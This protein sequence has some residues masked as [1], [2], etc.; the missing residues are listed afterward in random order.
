ML[1]NHLRYAWRT[2]TRHRTT[3]LI[4]ILG[5]SLGLCACIAI[6]TITHY[7]FSFDDFHPDK[8]RIYR[9]G[10]R[11]LEN[12]NSNQFAGVFYTEDIPPPA[13]D[14]IRADI[15]GIE[16]VAPY[17]LFDNATIIAT[18]DYFH[19]FR[20]DWVAGDPATALTGPNA[21]VLTESQ[22]LK[23]FGRQT[24]D[25]WLGKTLTIDDSLHLRVTGI[26]KDW[27]GNT[28]FPQ[29]QFISFPTISHSFLNNQY[30]PDNW[31]ASRDN[32][33]IRALI[34]IKPRSD[35]KQTEKQV[36]AILPRYHPVDT[37]QIHVELVLQP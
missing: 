18:N 34:K 23:R 32:P 17:Y 26:L 37:V 27:T 24:P 10:G 19:I 1:E 12:F 15:P 29:T 35:P 28:D 33:W 30:F 13:P 3:T 21:I 14:R 36:A 6:F 22:A 9:L 31:Q 11:V 2:L 16:T 8:A 7:E 25:A 20:Y 4:N 5:L